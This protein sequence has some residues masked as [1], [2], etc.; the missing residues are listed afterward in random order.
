M[1]ASRKWYKNDER[2]YDLFYVST[3]EMGA[4]TL[5]SCAQFED[6]FW[7]AFLLNA[8]SSYFHTTL[9]CFWNTDKVYYSNVQHSRVCEDETV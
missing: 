6:F 8:K 4:N 1:D 2:T 5:K 9:F 7:A 3:A